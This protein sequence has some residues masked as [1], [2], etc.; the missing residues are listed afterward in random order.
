MQRKP[1][2]S[3]KPCWRFLLPSPPPLATLHHSQQN[4]TV[5]P[6]I[7]ISP[8]SW[9]AATFVFHFLVF[10]RRPSSN[11]HL[12]AH[13]AA[14]PAAHLPQVLRL[15]R[16]PPVISSCLQT[17]AARAR[18]TDPRPAPARG[19]PHQ[20]ALRRAVHPRDGFG[21]AKADEEGFPTAAPVK[22]LLARGLGMLLRG[23]A[24]APR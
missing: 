17:E 9:C 4:K 1:A 6:Q 8:L 16:P 24:G 15:S 18:I 22:E 12:S 23:S 13:S 14:G 11:A 5:R 3:N 20:E 19:A 10:D 7:S 21:S 2:A